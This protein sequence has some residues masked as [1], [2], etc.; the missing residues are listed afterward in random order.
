MLTDCHTHLDSI[1]K[2]QLPRVVRHAKDFGVGRI[3][4]LGM[5][6]G[7]SGLAVGFANTYD[8]V[9]AGVGIHPMRAY[10]VAEGDYDKLKKL[11][12]SSQKIV[13]IG[14]IGLDYEQEYGT[15]VFVPHPAIL[16]PPQVQ[17]EIFRRLIR[18]AIELK[19]PVNVHSRRSSSPDVLDILKEEKAGL[20][21]GIFHH[22]MANEKVAEE[23]FELNNFSNQLLAL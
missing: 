18:L 15:G 4:A 9:Y 11:A 3:I 12:V 10:D 2:E 20:V 1:P 22:F 19:L 6:S 8:G 14:E 23:M 17:K 7:S 16:A 21:G 5:D 13:C